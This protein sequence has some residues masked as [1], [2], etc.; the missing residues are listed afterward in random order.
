MDPPTEE[1]LRAESRK[2]DPQD[3]KVEMPDMPPPPPPAADADADTDANG[4]SQSP[5]AS[6]DQKEGEAQAQAQAQ[7]QGEDEA[8]AASE[9]EKVKKPNTNESVTTTKT[10]T[11]AATSKPTMP[12]GLKE[13]KDPQPL[14]ERRI[15]FLELRSY[16]AKR[17]TIYTSKMKSTNLYWRAFRNMLAQA[18]EET[19]RAENLVRGTLAANES[20]A[21]FLT[22][23][24]EDRLDYAGKPVDKKR[25]ERI[26][27]ER[28]HKYSSLGGG[29][30]LSAVAAEQDRMKL[31]AHKSDEFENDVRDHAHANANANANHNV[32]VDGLPEH[33]ML[34]SLIQSQIEMANVMTENVNF[35][36][37]ISL[38][39]MHALRKELEAEVSVMGA[40]GDATMFELK[41]AEDDVQKSWGKFKI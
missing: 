33:S 40:L 29:G 8:A 4:V 37:E 39:K 10:T 38:E 11:N 17:R 3:A 1:E 13:T 18:Y 26:K 21:N 2:P 6:N 14:E 16:E 9:A 25:G 23:A 24:A 36:K 30:L 27:A 5:A 12:G 35:V 32:S 31:D 34:H 7:A 15:Q 19:D 20:Y 28:G 22:A 41:K